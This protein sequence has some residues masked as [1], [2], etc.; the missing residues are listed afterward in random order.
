[1]KVVEQDIIRE[2]GE[3][4]KNL[5]SKLPKLP[6]KVGQVDIMI[7]KHYLRYFLLEI[8]RL[9]S[10]LT[11]YDSVF[12]RANGSTGV[13]SG[14]HSEF[15]KIERS[16][17]FSNKKLCYYAPM[18]HNYFTFLSNQSEIPTFGY[19]KSFIDSD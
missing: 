6:N 2:I 12:G 19:G 11:L 10:G 4:D 16:S 15:S 7:G 1:M 13:V 8:T 5:I 18:V 14:P 3:S 9:K 17:H